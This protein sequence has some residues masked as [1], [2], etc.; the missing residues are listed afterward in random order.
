[1]RLFTG[2]GLPES[3]IDDISRLIDQLRPAAHLRWS[4]AYNL[5]ITTKFIGQWP[6]ARLEELK[7]ALDPLGKRSPFE[8]AVSGIGWLPN[9]WSPRVLYADVKAGPEL[10][11]LAVDTDEALGRL[12][13]EKETRKFAP[14]LT[15]ARIKDSGI[16]LDPLRDT[17]AKIEK[18]DFGRFVASHFS[19][20]LS[21]PGPAGSIYT[22]LAEFPFSK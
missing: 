13:I 14:H 7:T 22:Q 17:L 20:H 2:I 19:L 6:E 1:M 8:I 21:R 18:L 12:G 16:P 3:L 11:K 4:A 15:L 5:H 9:A 10:E